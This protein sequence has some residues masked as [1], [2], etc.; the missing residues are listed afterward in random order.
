MKKLEWFPK[1]WQSLRGVY[2]A[3][4]LLQALALQLLKMTENHND[5]F[6]FWTCTKLGLS[7]LIFLPY[8]T[9][10]ILALRYPALIILSLIIGG[11][12]ILLVGESII[13][14]GNHILAALLSAFIVDVLSRTGLPQVEQPLF[15]FTVLG[16]LVFTFRLFDDNLEQLFWYWYPQLSLYTLMGYT[17]IGE[18]S[19]SLVKKYINKTE[20]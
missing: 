20:T 12:S 13:L 16:L 11:I 2:L 19:T 10:A 15:S 9:S 7:A 14:L 3:V 6:T 4:I 17:I 1:D 8:V 18:W 5:L